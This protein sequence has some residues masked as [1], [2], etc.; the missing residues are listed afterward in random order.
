MA[1][2]NKWSK[3][4]HIK[5]RTDAVKGKV[6]SKIA[7]ELLVAAKQ[8]GADPEMNAS[9]R[10]II[11]KAKQANMPRENIA[12]AIE[13]GAGGGDDINL[14]ELIYEAYAPN[15]VALVIVCL[16]DNKNRTASNI[17]AILSKGGANLA[18]TGAVSYLFE[19]KGFIYVD[20]VS[21]LDLLMDVAIEAGALDVEEGDQSQVCISTEPKDF[22]HILDQLSKKDF[23]VFSSG[24]ENV[25]D[26]TVLLDSEKSQ[27]ML[28]LI[29]QL[30]QDDDVQSVYGNYEISEEDMANYYA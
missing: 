17:R 2:H 19:K 29:D 9:L 15:G 5:A 13:K 24:I 16:T 14:E 12:R 22:E 27:K 20:Q 18:A 7:R 23:Q 30:E 25:A 4:K 28:R 6:F 26:T 8:G 21:D 11:Q 1:G 10:L 3:V